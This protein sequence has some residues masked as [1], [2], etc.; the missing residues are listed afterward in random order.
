M[1]RR[2]RIEPSLD[3]QQ[4]FVEC[5]GLVT[6]RDN[7]EARLF[8]GKGGP[9]SLLRHAS[10]PGREAHGLPVNGAPLEPAIRVVVASAIRLY[11]EGL[12]GSLRNVPAIEVVGTAVGGGG[13]PHRNAGVGAGRGRGEGAAAAG[14]A[15]PPNSARAHPP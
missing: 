6:G 2:S 3:A 11:R 4:L 5:S 12:A 14:G 8:E 13:G 15:P 1:S 7:C 10:V 9:D